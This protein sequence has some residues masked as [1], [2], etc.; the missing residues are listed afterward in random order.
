MYLMREES[1]TTLLQTG[2]SLGGRDHTT[3]MVACDKVAALI[4]RDD[5]LRRIVFLIR[6]HLYNQQTAV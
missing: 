4:E 6:D 2:A 3:A 5:L 1:N